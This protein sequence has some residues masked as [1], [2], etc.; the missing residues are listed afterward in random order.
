MVTGVRRMRRAVTRR[1]PAPTV[2]LAL[3]M[4]PVG[5]GNWKSIEV[6]VRG[7]HIPP[8][9]MLQPGERVTIGQT[10]MRVVAVLESQG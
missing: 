1:S 3:I 4:R 6:R 5:R 7:K 8:P 10:V 2:S 9:L